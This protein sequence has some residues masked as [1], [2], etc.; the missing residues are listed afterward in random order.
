MIYHS[1][2]YAYIMVHLGLARPARE[3]RASDG[4]EIEIEIE[5]E[6]EMPGGPRRCHRIG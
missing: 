6:I 3:R 2:V 1:I 4:R 5:I